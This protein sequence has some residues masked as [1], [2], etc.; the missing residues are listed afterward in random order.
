ML[1]FSHFLSDEA[2]ILI[3]KLPDS[4]VGALTRIFSLC[5]QASTTYCF[6]NSKIASGYIFPALSQTLCSALYTCY[7]TDPSQK[8]SRIDIIANLQVRKLRLREVK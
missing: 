6:S 8:P 1:K 3:P 7:L 4:E 2:E 5:S